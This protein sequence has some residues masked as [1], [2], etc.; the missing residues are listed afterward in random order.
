MK[1]WESEVRAWES[2]G[3]QERMR[4]KSKNVISRARDKV[5]SLEMRSELQRGSERCG[6]KFY[7]FFLYVQ[8]S[9]YIM[10]KFKMKGWQLLNFT[11][12]TKDQ[13]LVQKSNLQNYHIQLI[14]PVAHFCDHHNISEFPHQCRAKAICWHGLA[15]WYPNML[16]LSEIVYWTAGVQCSAELGVTISARHQPKAKIIGNC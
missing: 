9:I 2:V 16:M 3:E 10:W 4:E 13:R 8:A 15:N 14:A 5:W 12:Y 1:V 11:A 7:L 6:V